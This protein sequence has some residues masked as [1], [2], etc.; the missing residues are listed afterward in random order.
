VIASKA[1]RV[2]E[3]SDFDSVRYGWHDLLAQIED[4]EGL[5]R[6]GLE[7]RGGQS[8]G[9]IEGSIVAEMLPLEGATRRR[10]ERD[11]P[12]DRLVGACLVELREQNGVRGRR[13]V[14]SGHPKDRAIPFDMEAGRHSVG[15]RARLAIV[16]AQ[17]VRRRHDRSYKRS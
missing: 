1:G 11:L 2:L 12:R 5:R 15:P 8:G 4:L 10:E 17:D 7:S 6:G 13:R 3:P 9:Q 16:P 14:R